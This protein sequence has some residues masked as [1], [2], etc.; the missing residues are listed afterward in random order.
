MDE[1]GFKVLE[2]VNENIRRDYNNLLSE[3]LPSKVGKIPRG[4]ERVGD[5]I[6]PIPEILEILI[7]EMYE[8]RYRRSRS[9]RAS[10][11]TIKPMFDL[12]AAVLPSVQ[13]LSGIFVNL[14]KKLGLVMT[15]TDFVVT[16]KKIIDEME[17]KGKLPTNAEIKKEYDRQKFEEGRKELEDHRKE[18]ARLKKR[19]V[20]HAKRAGV[21]PEN[22]KKA[23]NNPKKE[24][25]VKQVSPTPEVDNYLR[26]L[27]QSAS[28]EVLNDL[29][30]MAMS[31]AANSSRKIA[32]LPT[33][34]QYDFISASED[35]VLYGGAAGGGKSYALLFDAVRYAHIKG[36]RGVLIRRTMPELRELIDISR[37]LYPQMFKGCKFHTQEKAWRFASGAI[38]EFGFLDN[39][40]DKYQ[41]QGKGYAWIG[42]DE[43]G[44]QETP[45]GFDYL[46][47][48]LRTTL[49]MKGAIRCTANPGS[50]WVKEMFIDPAP[51]NIAF[52]DKVGLTYRFIPSLV[53][54]NPYIYQKGEGQY[55]K[56]LKSMSEVEMRQLLYGDWNVSDDSA[57]PEFDIRKHVI[58]G[59]TFVP[60][61]WTRFAG[62]D[63][64][65]SDQSASIWGAVNPANGQIVI[66]KEF[67]QSGLVGDAFAR[68]ILDEEADELVNVDHA[69]DWSVWNK[70][71][72]IG[73]TIGESMQRAG[74]RMRRADKNREGGKVQI[75]SRLRDIDE[76]TP[77][78][79]I[80]ESCP[81]LIR[82]LQSLRRHPDKE[83]IKQTRMNGDHNDLYDALRYGL[84]SRPRQQTMDQIQSLNKQTNAWKHI[85]SM[86]S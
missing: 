69:V 7:R 74:L 11:D 75:H 21:S 29:Y 14:E 48:R 25:R 5:E 2:K 44:L 15:K 36:Y 37:E 41:Y 30:E 32:F 28:S 34:K 43:L 33:P 80:L 54:D 78:L 77:G 86:F 16:R 82:E 8:V 64:G 84:M 57:F 27:N 55:I 81:K 59:G 3:H 65:Y 10:L 62:I 50:L 49:N 18:E 51:A 76:D 83:D 19:V 52:R 9:L 13:G 56:M 45:E 85:N 23:S 40:A 42:F 12:N 53:S 61:H 79:V 73:P 67:A 46:K 70:T 39:P 22:I 6:I 58:D 66:Y 68:V 38:L 71:G 31:E 47:S 72:H 24:T 35:I 60:K 26:A 4:Y 20:S 1:A 17:A 63:Y